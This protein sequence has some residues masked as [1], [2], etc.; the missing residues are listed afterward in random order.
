MNEKRHFSFKRLL[1][2]C[3]FSSLAQAQRG[4]QGWED[5]LQGDYMPAGGGDPI[6]FLLLYLSGVG[7]T[8][9]FVKIKQLNWSNGKIWIMSLWTM[10]IIGLLYILLF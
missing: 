3:L 8:Y 2:I 5:T 9:A 6:F 1:F 7:V 10:Q 4:A